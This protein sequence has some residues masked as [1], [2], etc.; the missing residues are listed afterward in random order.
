MLVQMIFKRR[1][2]EKGCWWGG[3]ILIGRMLTQHSQNPGFSLQHSIDLWVAHTGETEARH[4]T[5]FNIIINIIIRYIVLVKTDSLSLER[6]EEKPQ[7][8][9]VTV[10][11]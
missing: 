1:E 4:S 6:E 11:V 3:G 10:P 5:S 8:L 2:T 9:R 7:D